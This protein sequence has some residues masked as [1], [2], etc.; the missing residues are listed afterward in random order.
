MALAGRKYFRIK[1]DYQSGRPDLNRRPLDPQEVISDVFA[2]QSNRGRSLS[3]GD[4]RVWATSGGPWSPRGHHDQDQQEH[5]GPVLPVRAVTTHDGRYSSRSVRLTN[6][7]LVRMAIAIGGQASSLQHPALPHHD[8][9]RR[10]HHRMNSNRHPSVPSPH[11]WQRQGET[12]STLMGPVLT[13][14]PPP[15]TSLPIQ[16][17]SPAQATGVPASPIRDS[18]GSL[19]S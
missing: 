1:S 18:S 13:H 16:A 8:G 7:S 6:G 15:V 14:R 12:A 5:P 10:S 19:G 3:T 4:Q 9:P 2:A 17:P 11:L